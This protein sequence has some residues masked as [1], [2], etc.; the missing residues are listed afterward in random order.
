MNAQLTGWFTRAQGEI[1]LN[2]DLNKLR[3]KLDETIHSPPLRHQLITSSKPLYAR[4]ISYRSM[5]KDKTSACKL[6]HIGL[7]TAKRRLRAYLKKPERGRVRHVTLPPDY[8]I[9]ST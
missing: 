5:L 3:L 4:I 2:A 1:E 9:N 8:Y 6:S 7:H